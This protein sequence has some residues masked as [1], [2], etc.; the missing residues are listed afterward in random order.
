MATVASALR[1]K[2]VAADLSNV[3]TK[4][5]R[6]FAPDSTAMPFITFDDDISRVGAFLGDSKISM[7]TRLV[8]VNLF[9]K[10]DAED[11][12]LIDSLFAALDS[13]DLTGADKNIVGCRVD[14]VVRF[15]TI[16]QNLCHHA[17]TVRITQAA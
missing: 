14:G 2:I 8:Q 6:D 1:T 12:T 11:V 5:F 4:V 7:S 15:A 9:Q 13:A 10:L 16:D 3:T 17:V